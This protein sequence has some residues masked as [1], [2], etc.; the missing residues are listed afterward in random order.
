MKDIVTTLMERD[1]LTREEAKEQV[2]A[3][4]LLLEEAIEDGEDETSLED[5]LMDELDLE[6]D[7]LFELL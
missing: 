4:K 6:P 1:D 3:I 7:Y 2:E 5:I